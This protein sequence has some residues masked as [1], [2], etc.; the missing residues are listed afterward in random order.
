[1]L[2]YPIKT[3]CPLRGGLNGK[4]DLEKISMIT[5][6]DGACMRYDNPMMMKNEAMIPAS[7]AILLIMDRADLGP[8]DLDMLRTATDDDLMAN[9]D[10][11][12]IKDILDLCSDHQFDALLD[13]ITVEFLDQYDDFDPED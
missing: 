12:L 7:D 2:A 13:L 10:L 11:A 3:S 8:E 5:L 1:M 9:L 4:K 6:H